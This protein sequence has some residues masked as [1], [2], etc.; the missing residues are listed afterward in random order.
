M[1]IQIFGPVAGTGYG[2]VTANLAQQLNTLPDTEVSIIPIGVM[3][4]SW[5]ND[6]AAHDLNRMVGLGQDQRRVDYTL[7]IWHEWDHPPQTLGWKGRVANYVAMPTFEL[8]RVRP[9]AVDCLS[10]I[11]RV[12][13]S[14]EHCLNVLKQHQ[15]TN[16]HM[17]HFHGVDTRVFNPSPTYLRER[18][19]TFNLI[20]IGKL[21]KRKGH[22]IC[23]KAIAWCLAEGMDV[24]LWGMWE[25]PFLGQHQYTL[26]DQ[27]VKEASEVYGVRRDR[28]TKAIVRLAPRPYPADVARLINSCHAGLYPFRAEGWNLPLLETLACGVPV[29]ASYNSGPKDYLAGSGAEFVSGTRLAAEDGIWFGPGKLE[30][31][32]AEPNIAEV[33]AG[34]HRLYIRWQSDQLDNPA[35]VEVAEEFTWQNAAKRVRRWLE[36]G[37]ELSS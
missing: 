9:E 7:C 6:S 18:A 12:L 20:N 11:P 4:T 24:Q 29:V 22:D 15:L 25:N 17:E 36:S 32:W 34:I 21:E 3:D 30:G 33:M 31:T 2:V 26:V 16:V 14:S 8:D 35:G 5:F 19:S 13:V 37:C 27:W 10:K 1:H 28:L 23:I